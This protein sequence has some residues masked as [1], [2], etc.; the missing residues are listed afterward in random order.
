MNVALPMVIVPER[1]AAVF[2]WT[3]KDTVPLPDPGEPPVTVIHVALLV[4]VQGH[5]AG[6]DTATVPAPPPGGTVF[7]DEPSVIGQPES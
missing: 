4:A 2:A 1:G 7:D 6:D 3:L 5:P